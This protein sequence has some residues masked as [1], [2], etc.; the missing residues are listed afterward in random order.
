[1]VRSH[2]TRIDF[3]G[4]IQVLQG[5]IEQT[6]VERLVERPE[7]LDVFLRHRPPS[8]PPGTAAFHAKHR[9]SSKALVRQ[10]GGFED[11]PG[12]T[13]RACYGLRTP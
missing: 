12:A 9:F 7:D 3:D 2:Y 6:P 1:M 5:V 10:P 4:P 11:S 13:A 8:I